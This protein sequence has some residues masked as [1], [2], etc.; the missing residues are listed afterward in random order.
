MQ[1][2]EKTI[3]YLDE[4]GKLNPEVLEVLDYLAGHPA[5]ILGTGHGSW[6]EI[7][8]LIRAATERGVRRILVNH[9][10]YMI[11]AS[12]VQIPGLSTVDAVKEAVS[13]TKYAPRGR[14]GLSFAQR[15]ASYGICDKKS[16]MEASNAGLIN[17]V[18]IENKEMAAQVKSLCELDGV[19]DCFR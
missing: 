13:Y 19:V 7:D 17:V 3:Y 16:Y 4:S 14:R 6:D 10:H 2:A 12:G 5:V 11:G 15:P 8:A 18:H 1:V 9:P